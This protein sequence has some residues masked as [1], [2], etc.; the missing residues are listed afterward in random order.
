MGWWRVGL[1]RAVAMVVGVGLAVGVSERMSQ[2][3]Q[4]LEGAAALNQS[5]GFSV[6]GKVTGEILWA[7][8]Q[9]VG[10]ASIGARTQACTGAAVKARIHPCMAGSWADEA[11]VEGQL[12]M[13]V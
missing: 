7:T 1:V 10:L 6:G 4:E 12:P 5:A 8:D 3:G 2:P 11:S 9:R 13:R